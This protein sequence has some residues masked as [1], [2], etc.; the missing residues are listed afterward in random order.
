MSV[1]F[2]FSVYF[3]HKH[4]TYECI[5]AKHH[6]KG[7]KLMHKRGIIR[8]AKYTV[9]ASVFIHFCMQRKN[10]EHI[11][12]E[13]WVFY[14]KIQCEWNWLFNVTCNDISVIYVIAHTCR[15]IEVEPTV[16]LPIQRNKREW[17]VHNFFWWVYK[18][19]I[20][21][22]N[23]ALSDLKWCIHLSKSLFL[24]ST[25]WWVSLLVDQWVPEGTWSQVLRSTSVDS[26]RFESIKISRVKNWLK[27]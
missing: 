12:I 4:D 22:K 5:D 2:T 24:I 11:L 21:N 17:M 18:N 23:L 3:P 27:L 13:L 26:C 6:G 9:C 10:N 16:G 8:Y 25:T 1:F 19:V 14:L 20:K 7:C 15:C